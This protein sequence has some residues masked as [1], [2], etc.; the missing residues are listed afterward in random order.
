M[1]V[2]E[3]DRNKN[4]LPIEALSGTDMMQQMNEDMETEDDIPTDPRLLYKKFEDMWN[5]DKEN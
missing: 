4:Q 3:F 5:K 2:K 1:D